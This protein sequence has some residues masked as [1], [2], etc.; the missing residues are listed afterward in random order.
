MFFWGAHFS[1]LQR[2]GMVLAVPE[3]RP[4]IAQHLS[5]GYAALPSASPAGTAESLVRWAGRPCRDLVLPHRQPSTEVPGY[6]R[7]SLRDG[8][9]AERNPVVL[10]HDRLA[11]GSDR[12]VAAESRLVGA[13]DRVVVRADR[14]VLSGDMLAARHG[15]QVLAQNRPVLWQNRLVLSQSRSFLGRGR[16]GLAV[17]FHG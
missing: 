2:R 17:G 4:R 12:V 14:L 13:W 8:S 16:A 3:G 10:R 1:V 7:S 6:F 11:V 15:R 5:A 9:D